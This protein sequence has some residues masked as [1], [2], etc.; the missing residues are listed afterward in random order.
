LFKYAG[1]SGDNSVLLDQLFTNKNTNNADKSQTLIF[2][3]FVRQLTD[4]SNEMNKTVDKN[5]FNQIK[6]K[7]KEKT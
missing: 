1:T 4:S 2:S 3:K 7:I 6:I 5:V